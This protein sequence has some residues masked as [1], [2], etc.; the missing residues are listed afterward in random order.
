MGQ[1]FLAF[2]TV[3]KRCMSRLIYKWT[4]LFSASWQ[5]LLLF[6]KKIVSFTL[7]IIGNSD[8]RREAIPDIPYHFY[9]VHKYPDI[10][11][12]VTLWVYLLTFKRKLPTTKVRVFIV[13]WVFHRIRKIFLLQIVY[14]YEQDIYE[15]VSLEKT[16]FASTCSTKSPAIVLLLMFFFSFFSSIFWKEQQKFCLFDY[17]YR[18]VWQYPRTHWGKSMWSK[19]FF[20]RTLEAMCFRENN[21]CCQKLVSVYNT[22]RGKPLGSWL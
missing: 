13:V 21:N 11:Q 20:V 16:F 22:E 7:T 15:Q 3:F 10:N 19:I 4:T 8:C 5:L 18:H 12:T 14:I 17:C 9:P 6:L 2:V 1:V